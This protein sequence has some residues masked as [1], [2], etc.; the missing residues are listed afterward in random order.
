ML[1]PR[2]VAYFE[3]PGKYKYTTTFV[4]VE[5]FTLAVNG[6]NVI[7]IEQGKAFNIELCC[8]TVDGDLTP[9]E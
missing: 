9:G 3:S 2:V 7:E 6:S 1:F 8:Q 5:A 4:I